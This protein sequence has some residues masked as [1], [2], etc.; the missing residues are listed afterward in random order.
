MRSVR[1]IQECN[2][3][4]THNILSE[5]ITSVQNNSRD[6]LIDFNWQHLLYKHGKNNGNISTHQSQSTEAISS[7]TVLEVRTNGSTSV[8]KY[9][10][11]FC[12][13]RATVSAEGTEVKKKSEGSFD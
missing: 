4:S 10:I 11:F 8:Q 12:Q 6:H 5:T 13:Y 1:T 2:V 3:Q 7:S 9:K